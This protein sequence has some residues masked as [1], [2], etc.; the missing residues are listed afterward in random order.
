MGDLNLSG[1][2]APAVDLVNHPPHYTKG[3]IEC[4]AALRAALGDAGFVSY[5]NGAAIKYLWRWRYKGGAEDLRKANWYINAMLETLE[6]DC[7]A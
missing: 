1:G 4:I 5:C 6:Q 2:Q 7:H 3:G